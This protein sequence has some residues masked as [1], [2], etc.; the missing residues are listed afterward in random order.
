MA[1]YELFVALEQFAQQ[2]PRNSVGTCRSWV[3]G[4]NVLWTCR[5]RA[6]PGAADQS[7]YKAIQEMLLEIAQVHGPATLLG[8]PDVAALASLDPPILDHDVLRRS[9]D[10]HPG[11]EVPA[12]LHRDAAATHQQFKRAL[13]R[14][15]TDASAEHATAAVKKLATTLYNAR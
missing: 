11:Q 1:Y 7:E 9:A 6:V 12:Q 13:E 4:L 15:T 2:N 5:R 14:W 10:Y 3:D 8:H